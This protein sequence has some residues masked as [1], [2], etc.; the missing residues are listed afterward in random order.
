[1]LPGDSPPLRG[2][3]KGEGGVLCIKMLG[4][5]IEKSPLEIYIMGL[6]PGGVKE[7]RYDHMADEKSITKES[8]DRA[9]EREREGGG[10]DSPYFLLMLLIGF[11]FKLR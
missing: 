10:V 5:I 11:Q 1:M 6:S 7:L 8:R 2:G 4:K 3:G 9:S